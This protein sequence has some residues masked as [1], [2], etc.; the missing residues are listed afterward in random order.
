[1]YIVF[2]MHFTMCLYHVVLESFITLIA[3]V[4]CTYIR[5]YGTHAYSSKGGVY[6]VIVGSY[7]SKLPLFE[8]FNLKIMM[9]IDTLLC[10]KYTQ[11]CIQIPICYPKLMYMVPASLSS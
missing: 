3:A 5:L 9:F 7:L 4:C 1:M 2:Y 6:S 10:I 8:Y 11:L